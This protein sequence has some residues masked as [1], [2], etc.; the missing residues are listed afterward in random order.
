MGTMLKELRYSLYLTTHP[1]KGFWE[2]KHENRG[3]LRTAV[4]WL[5]AYTLLSV[6][7]G[8]CTAYLFNH[9]GC[10]IFNLYNSVATTLALFFLWCI[11]N[12]CLTS[13]YDGEGKFVDIV[14][15]TAYALIPLVLVN[16]ILI[17]M[18]YA[19]V[20]TEASF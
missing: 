11:S 14:K 10:V 15:A 5:A 7:S 9:D 18:S 1:F 4:F 3:S 8:F 6:L 16:I 20:L 19:L 17:P 12:W 2:I 13:L